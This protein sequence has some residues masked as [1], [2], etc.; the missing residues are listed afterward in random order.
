MGREQSD[1]AGSKAGCKL[2]CRMDDVAGKLAGAESL[3]SRAQQRPAGFSK[4]PQAALAGQKAPSQDSQP[5][6]MSAIQA[7]H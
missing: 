2:S 7:V 5:S 4:S 3:E 6:R 1:V